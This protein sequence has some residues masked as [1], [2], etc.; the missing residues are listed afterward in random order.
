MSV[1]LLSEVQGTC[2]SLFFRVLFSGRLL[3]VLAF[4]LICFTVTQFCTADYRL[5]D[6]QE[7]RREQSEHVLLLDWTLLVEEPQLHLTSCRTASGARGSLLSTGRSLSLSV[8]YPSV[9]GSGV[10]GCSTRSWDQCLPAGVL[11][12]CAPATH[13]R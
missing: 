9:N 4:V 8:R 2:F 12:V 1:E 7:H 6:L 11:V 3:C 13:Q 5:L 10:V